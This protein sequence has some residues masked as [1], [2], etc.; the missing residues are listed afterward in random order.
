MLR[1]LLTLVVLSAATIAALVVSAGASAGRGHGGDQKLSKIG[2]IVVIYEENHS[3][4]NL[5]GRWERVR[6]LSKADTSHTTQLGQTGPSSFAPYECLYQDDANLQAQSAA[7]PSGPLSTTCNN[8]TGGTFPSHFRNRPFSIDDYLSADDITCPPVLSAFSFPNGIRKQGINPVNGQPVPDA[9]PGGCTRDIVHRFYEEQF[10]LNGG[11]QN[12]YVVQSDAAGLVMGTY[13]TRK[14][15]V[16]EYL[17]S[18]GHPK[19]AILDNFFQ[20]AFGGSYLNHQWLIAAATPV[21]NAANGCPANATHS[22]LDRNGSPTLVSPPASN[23]PPGMGALYTS[24]DTGLVNGVLTQ[25]CGLPTTRT[26]LACG[27]FSVNTQQPAFQPSGLFGAKLPAQTNPTIGD[28]LNA[29]GVDWAWYSGGWSNANGNVGDPGWTNGTG[30]A[31]TPTGCTD[32]NVDPGVAHWPECPDNLFQ[33]HHQPFNYYAAFS[34]QTP[35]GLAN[36]AAHLRDEQEFIQDAEGSTSHCNLKPVS[37]IKPIGEEN[38]HPGYASEPDGSDHLVDLLQSIEN[39]KCKNDTLV[40]VTY[41]EFGGQWD[42][43]PPPGQGNNNGPHDEWGPGTR[44]PALVL[45]PHLKGPFV[46]DHTEYD[47]TT[48][49][50]TIEQRY[51]LAPLGMRDA[52]MNTLA[53][54]FDAH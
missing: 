24:P 50:S 54:V 32:P 30:P 12:R 46:V 4:D 14:L 23:Q 45:G 10:Q 15:P 52:A 8:V 20:A 39:S 25:S 22:V 40:L 13:D 33:Y 43:V 37:I 17:H 9:R 31:M 27:D 53:N 48:V 19:Y 1:R 21:C 28:R 41:D 44:I 42:H 34:T 35:T 6:G 16:Y 26:W 38:E 36:R 3:F 11:H 47:T 51:G 18:R 7:N 49:L 5:Y 29:A 2:H